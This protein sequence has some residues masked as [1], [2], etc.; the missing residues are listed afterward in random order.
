[1]GGKLAKQSIFVT[2]I[3]FIG[4]IISFV[5]ETVVANY[6]GV[7]A[8]VD[9]YTVAIT[10]PVNL[11]AII[12]LAI[13]PIVIPIYSNLRI[14]RSEEQANAYICSLISIIGAISFAFI[15]L[16]EILA[17]P[18]AY[19]F[20][21]GLEQETH[22]LVVSLLRI[23]L[24]T[25]FFTLLDRVL[26]GVMNV[27]KQ[28]VLP[29]LSVY[30]LNLSVIVMIVFLHS[31][32]GITAACFGQVVGAVLQI[33][34]LAFFARKYIHFS[35]RLNFRDESIKETGRNVIPVIWSTSVA[36][37]DAIINRAVASFLFVGAISSLGYATKVNTVLMT[38][39]TSA[40]ATIV[41]PLYAEASAKNDLAQLNSRVNT[42][43]SIYAFLLLPLVFGILCL[44]RELIIV[45]FARGA[46]DAD[47]V[48]L[49][50]SLLGCYCLGI[51]F[52]AFR[53]TITKVYYALHD[54]MTP[55]KN[56]TFGLIINIVLNL[57]LP[58]FLGV[59]GLAL[60]TS[61]SAAFMAIGLLYQLTQ[62]YDEINLGMTMKEIAKMMLP[63][64]VMALFIMVLKLI[65]D[66]SPIV[67]L[68]AGFV[69]GSIIYIL[70]S[71]LLK[72]NAFMYLM[73][74]VFKGIIKK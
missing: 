43:L 33:L 2:I 14:N 62:K 27:H 32:Y 25:V 61:I 48:D 22:Q 28:F 20:A 5:K 9:A 15:V 59:Q 24:P 64:A 30:F 21:P 63:V 18:I 51:L 23:T 56:T 73:S 65:T 70:V 47:A 4:Y 68:L 36:E 74:S 7:S 35:F 53:E 69:S 54:T 52:L 37:L 71:Y 17:S 29:S 72:I 10:I 11:F 45:A 49:T 42:T 38:F 41:Y 67:T 66:F 34:F 55:A 46:F 57:T 50:Q 26:V 8:E 44:K 31:A 60:A 12:A 40:I 6:F 19:L 39:F 3:L 58:F 1:M 16:F 13:Q